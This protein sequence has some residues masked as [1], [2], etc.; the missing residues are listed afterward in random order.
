MLGTSRVAP[1][2]VSELKRC[3]GSLTFAWIAAT[4]FGSPGGRR[5]EVRAFGSR[6]SFYVILIVHA[7]PNYKSANAIIAGTGFCQAEIARRL[8]LPARAFHLKKF[9]KES[10]RPQSP[11]HG[12][13]VFPDGFATGCGFDAIRRRHGHRRMDTSGF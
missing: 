9:C 5:S 11:S 12:I 10:G 13:R 3:E 1:T 4:L 8:E 2:S 7:V 6:R